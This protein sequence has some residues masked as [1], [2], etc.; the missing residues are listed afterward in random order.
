MSNEI[1][2]I[3]T[4]TAPAADGGLNAATGFKDSDGKYH[5]QA[6][7]SLSVGRAKNIAE[8]ADERRITSEEAIRQ[9]LIK[10]ANV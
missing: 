8:F 4:S 9:A 6:A 3:I 2:T 10:R 5:L 7:V 1:N